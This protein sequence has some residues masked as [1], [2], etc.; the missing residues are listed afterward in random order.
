[1]QIYF[2]YTMAASFMVEGNCAV[3]GG[4]PQPYTGR[5]ETFPRMAG[6][7]VIMSWT[8]SLSNWDTWV[9]RIR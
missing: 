6:E 2:T 1:M 8:W 3:G 9:N 4:N 7:E 5:R